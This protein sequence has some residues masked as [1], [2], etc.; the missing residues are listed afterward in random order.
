VSRRSGAS[1]KSLSPGTGA[2]RRGGSDDERGREARRR[3]G[4][5][6]LSADLEGD[7]AYI[8]PTTFLSRVIFT[9]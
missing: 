3:F 1:E 5:K 4:G 9:T 7:G 6:R 2:A 8:E